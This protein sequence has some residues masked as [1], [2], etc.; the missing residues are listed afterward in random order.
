MV[1][2]ASGC[3]RRDIH[4]LGPVQPKD[5]GAFRKVPVVTDVDPYLAKSCLEDRIRRVSGFEVELFQETMDLWYVLLTI[6]TQKG[7]IRIYNGR[8]VVINRYTYFFVH[9]S[10]NH[11]AVLL[12]Y[13]LKKLSGRALRDRLRHGVPAAV[14]NLAEVGGVE[15]FLQARDLGASPMG[16]FNVGKMFF[17][18]PLLVRGIVGL[19]EGAAHFHGG[20]LA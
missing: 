17:D 15:E 5:P 7:T 19:D 13:I 10:D 18:V 12:G 1:A 3:V 4:D 9:R 16:F 11:H 6:L 20:N 8:G 14:L 2:E